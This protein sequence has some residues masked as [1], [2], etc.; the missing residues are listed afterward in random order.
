MAAWL[1]LADR[2]EARDAL[3][4]YLTEWRKV[5]SRADGDT[6]RALNLPPGPAYRRIL[7]SLR[8]AWL[9][10]VISTAKGE[11]ALLHRLVEEAKAHNEGV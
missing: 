4:R 3:Y 7:W 9:D 5:T 2:P 10:G 11:A 8:A 6:L 1:A